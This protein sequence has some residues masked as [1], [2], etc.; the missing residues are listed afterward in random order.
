MS[1]PSDFSGRLQAAA[2][3]TL[4]G[5]GGAEHW[6]LVLLDR[7]ELSILGSR[8]RPANSQLLRVL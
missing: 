4:P 3:K 5:V 2:T 1:A 6:W 7:P 8:L